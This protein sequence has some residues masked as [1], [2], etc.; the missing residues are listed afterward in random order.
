M[1]PLPVITEPFS[2]IAIDIVG[3]LPICP[4]SQNRFILTVLDLATHYP[5]AIALHEHTAPTVAKALTTVFSKFGFPL[6]ILSDQGTDFMSDVMRHFTQEFDIKQIRTSPYRPQTN[7]SCERFNRTMKSMIRSLT[8]KFH[9]SW[10]EC[11]QWVLFAYREIPVETVG[12]SPFELLFGR[13]IRGPL[14]LLK[15][16]WLQDQDSNQGVKPNVLKY[17]MDLRQKLQQCQE[18]ALDTANEAKTN[19][20]VWYDRRSRE[21]EF[22]IGQL[23]LV[24]LPMAGKPL[25]AKY[26]GPYK[27]IGKLGPVDYVIATPNKR[28][29]QR[30]CHVNMLKAY[31]ERDW[32]TVLLNV[33]LPV[34]D[35]TD[36]EFITD[37]DLATTDKN[38]AFNLSHIEDPNRAELQQ[39]LSS[40]SDIFN[41]VPGKTTLCSH[42]IEIKPG[43]RPIKLAPYRA[44]PEKADQIRKELDQMIKMGVIEESNSPWSSPVVLIPKPDGSIRFCID[45]RRVNDITQPDAFPLPRIEDLIDKIGK[46]KFL[47][48]NRFI[49]GILAG[50]NGRRSNSNISLCYT[51]W[52]ISMEIYAVWITKCARYL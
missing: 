27:I 43:A 7:G 33:C 20:K 49:P 28:R 15:S 26:Q 35:D 44:N 38:D 14:G 50:T 51:S 12:F 31:V 17:I 22:D 36:H 46:A 11:L 52:P 5:E 24:L 30:V 3:P 6:E 1:V 21:R 47:T 19:S 18:I 45:Y 41:D 2:R 32:K 40:Y 34:P 4:K 25:D 42:K 16:S 9:D 37:F 13:N 29:S 23:V 8:D 48:K 10:D 39:L